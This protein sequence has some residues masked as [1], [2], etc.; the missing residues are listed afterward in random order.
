MTIYRM[1]LVCTLCT[2]GLAA[3]EPKSVAGYGNLP[4]HFESNQGQWDDGSLFAGIASR[5]R[6]AVDRQG[7]RLSLHTGGTIGF[8]FSQ[9][10][11]AA[12]FALRDPLPGQSSYLLGPEARHHYK[13]IPHYRRVHA[14]AIY[15]GIDAVYYGRGNEVEYDFIVA[16][17]ASPDPISLRISGASHVSLDSNGDLLLATH[18]GAVRQ[19]KPVAYQWS[20][21][22]RQFVEARYNL[23]NGAV[24]FA[25]GPYDRNRPLI[26]DPSLAYSVFFNTGGFSHALSIE[27]DAQGSAYVAGYVY[28]DGKNRGFVI[29]L[30]PAGTAVLS[31]LFFF[32]GFP[33]AIRLDAAGAAYIAGSS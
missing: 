1:G 23:D 33:T 4:V 7:F 25:L 10:N 13:D 11:P 22:R 2:L 32:G 16:P 8:R 15:P 30:N 18:T 17:H 24:S 28:D 26:I 14:T 9:S 3:S 29:K 12:S 31:S 5:Y 19:R 21:T 6:F 20:G 27:V